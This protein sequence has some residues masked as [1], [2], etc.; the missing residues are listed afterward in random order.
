MA[1]FEVVT[2]GGELLN[3]VT[4]VQELT[5]VAIYVGD[6]RLRSCCRQKARVVCE[7][8]GLRVEL[9]DIDYIGTYGSF[10][11]GQVDAWRA[12]A[13]GDCCFVVG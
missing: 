4:A 11:N 9:T 10:V 3:G 7:H 1:G 5:F 13:E 2:V 12:V 6:G 8:A